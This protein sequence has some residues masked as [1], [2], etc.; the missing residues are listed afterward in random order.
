[1]IRVASLVG[2]LLVIG[3]TY[4]SH[5]EQR[6]IQEGGSFVYAR[7]LFKL[8]ESWAPLPANDTTFFSLLPDWPSCSA[9]LNRYL[10][11]K[12]GYDDIKVDDDERLVDIACLFLDASQ[13]RGGE[14]VV[15][16][17]LHSL[18]YAYPLRELLFQEDSQ[19]S[20]FFHKLCTQGVG[21]VVLIFFEWCW[22]RGG[23][24]YNVV[25]DIFFQCQDSNQRTPYS[26]L[27][28]NACALSARLRL[29]MVVNGIQGERGRGWPL[30]R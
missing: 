26:Y 18:S 12:Y 24:P 22:Q 17:L 23:V 14:V 15:R 28:H 25:Y 27:F 9:W 13:E 30:E 21:E 3:G 7:S 6:L 2:I 1:M 19:Q 4:A 8:G 16:S 11:N 5:G 10:K 29:E 20:T